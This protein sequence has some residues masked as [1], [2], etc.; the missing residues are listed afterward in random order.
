MENSIKEII[1]KV[2]IELPDKFQRFFEYLKSNFHLEKEEYIEEIVKE[3]IISR[4][5]ELNIF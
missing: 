5:S 1:M 3:E 4:N 2:E